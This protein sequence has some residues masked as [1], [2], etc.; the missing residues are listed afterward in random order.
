MAHD[1]F[2]S[3]SSQDKS[4]ADALCAALEH[5]AIRCWIAPRDVQPGRSFAGEITRAIQR[6][7][8]M[9]LVFSAHSNASEQVLREV[10]LAANSHLHIVQFRIEDILPNDDL[11][12]Y[13]S[14][15]HWLDALSPPLENHLG[16]L[17]ASIKALLSL[18]AETRSPEQTASAEPAA[19]NTPR[20]VKIPAVSVEPPL[21]VGTEPSRAPEK[22]EISR[23]AAPVAPPKELR[24]NRMRHPGLI[25]AALALLLIISGLL[26]FHFLG[27]HRG[28]VAAQNSAPSATLSGHEARTSNPAKNNPAAGRDLSFVFVDLNRVFKEYR[29]TKEAE[30]KINEAKNAAKIEYDD[31]AN[32]YKTE[33][34]SYNALS[35]GPAKDLLGSELKAME[36]KINDFRTTR[37]KELQDHA[38]HLR[39]G[40]VQE[41]R[42]EI[43]ELNSPENNIIIDTTG[44]SLNG[45]PFV[46]FSA[47]EAD[48]TSRVIAGLNENADA[49]LRATRG[50]FVAIVDM[51]DIF[52]KLKKTK[53][54]ESKINE[55]KSAAKQEYDIRA[56]AYKKSLEEINE[57]NRQL[58]LPGHRGKAQERDAKVVA[59]KAMEK[60]INDFR[61]TRE[62]QLAEQSKQL[63]NEIVKEIEQHIA[64]YAAGKK[65]LIFDSSA[66]TRSANNWLIY[67]HGLPDLSANMISELNEGRSATPSSSDFIS[68]DNFK[69]GQI[70][71]HRVTE[72]LP[73]WEGLKT[74][75]KTA[76]DKAIEELGSHPTA[77]ARAT[78]DKELTAFNAQKYKPLLE[79]IDADVAALGRR[80]GFHLIYNSAG[81]SLNDVTV[82]L[83]TREVPDLT[84]E[85]I[86]DLGGK[87]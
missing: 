11:E 35:A 52:K 31:R 55:A 45:V 59:I 62:S 7:K 27:P 50:L 63:R 69:I 37:E 13:L 44:Q 41:I 14:T 49:K 42:A 25:A 71:L 66:L 8:V 15:P 23:A 81:R 22:V 24:L 53:I 5:A 79:K 80:G 78:K 1:V 12:Y 54:S 60:E 17:T 70:D 82:V 84:R 86:A 46:Q 4:V 30:A 29:K 2:I 47:E 40:I 18:G 26:L 39:E 34:N 43:D 36:T 67:Q 74:E 83:S 75:M 73:E 68:S 19:T 56:D 9:V 3:H 85:V 16:R 32:A 28:P 6:S 64:Q 65:Y 20:E 57:L 76:K 87:P 58:Q 10:Q 38:L 72:A 61:Q 33:L 51:N 21:P 77:E 48:M